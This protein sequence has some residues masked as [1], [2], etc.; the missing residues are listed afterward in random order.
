VTDY[1][2][3]KERSSQG[4]IAMEAEIHLRGQ[5]IQRGNEKLRASLAEKELLLKEVHH[6][7]KNN[8]EII[9]SL[10]TL[11]ADSIIDSRVRALLEDTSNRVRAIADIHH[12]LYRS[13]DFANIDVRSF[14]EALAR[15]LLSTLEQDPR[16]QI[17]V[18]GALQVDI[19]R[20]VPVSLI[21]NELITNALKHAFP[22]HRRGSIHVSVNSDL[23]ES[24]LC[25][26]DDGIGLS[27]HFN[28]A[29]SPSLGLQLVKVL[30]EQL[31]GA[32]EIQSP[33]GSRFRIRFPT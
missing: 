31:G 32:L 19:Q 4:A 13:E 8:L 24:W 25:V 23:H 33:Q 20:A 16:I 18:E 21:L 30:T 5:E 15:Q 6:R 28:P 27:P 22:N 2:Q 11:Q 29:K 26:A 14:A 7:V 10:V 9:S 3:L 12:L 17:V 1:V